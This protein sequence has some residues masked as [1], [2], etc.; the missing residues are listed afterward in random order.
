MKYL[1]LKM[2]MKWWNSISKNITA[3]QKKVTLLEVYNTP[4]TVC[5]ILF[6]RPFLSGLKQHLASDYIKQYQLPHLVQVTY[7]LMHE[8]EVQYTQS[9]QII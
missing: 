8:F 6:H 7:F 3:N 4:K 9:C 2:L 1:S 5:I